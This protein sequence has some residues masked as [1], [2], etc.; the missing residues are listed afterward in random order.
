M[1]NYKISSEK[2]EELTN[3]FN[4]F[5]N[6][7]DGFI[8]IKE[9][10]EIMTLLSINNQKGKDQQEYSG[11]Q[12]Y[13]MELKEFLYNYSQQVVKEA[14]LIEELKEAFKIID[15]DKDS[16]INAEDFKYFMNTLGDVITLEECEELI[17]DVTKVENQGMNFDEFILVMKGLV[18]K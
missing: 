5:D 11:D 8:S 17:C 1:D 2:L 13:K 6:D 3:L 7:Q 10:D 14:D 16:Y 9:Y 15:Q 4:I 12:S 18:N